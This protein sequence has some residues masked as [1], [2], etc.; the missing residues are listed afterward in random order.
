MYQLD[1]FSNQLSKLHFCS[2]IEEISQ[3]VPNREISPQKFKSF[4]NEIISA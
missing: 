4:G 1:E 2:K 3:N